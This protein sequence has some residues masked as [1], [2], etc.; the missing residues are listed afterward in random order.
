M[1]AW[2]DWEIIRRQVTIGGR[3]VGS[4]NQPL[5]GVKMTLTSLPDSFKPQVEGAARAMEGRWEELEQR[6]D[7]FT[8]RS[9]GMYYFL[10]LPEGKY[11]LQAYDSKTQKQDD[12]EVIVAKGKKEYLKVE[13]QKVLLK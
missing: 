8:T 6:P 13:I 3:V 2:T 11:H 10:D 12:M 9:A 1:R 4:H 7:R 5:V